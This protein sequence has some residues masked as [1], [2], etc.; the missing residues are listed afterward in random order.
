MIKIFVLGRPGS[1]KSTA[2]RYIEEQAKS[3]RFSVSHISDLPILYAMFYAD[4]EYKQF[5]P[6]PSNDFDVI[7]FAAYDTAILLLGEKARKETADVVIIEFGRNDYKRAFEL[8]GDDLRRD[9]FFLFCEATTETCLSRV[10]ARNTNSTSPDAHPTRSDERYR[11]Y[12]GKNNL[13]YM[14]SQFE[15]DFQFDKQRLLCIFNEELSEKE[16]LSRVN[17]F[18]ETVLFPPFPF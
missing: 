4:K 1:G 6:N 2:A 13:N 18:A 15:V 16:F 3:R 10:H 17:G 11:D 14:S 8:L 9:A 5:A 12:Y 7:D